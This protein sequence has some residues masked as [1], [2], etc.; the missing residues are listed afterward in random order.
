MLIDLTLRDIGEA[1]NAVD[2]FAP[3]AAAAGAEEALVLALPPEQAC[4]T[5]TVVS[6][7]PVER[8]EFFNTLI[9]LG[10]R[11]GKDIEHPWR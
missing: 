7:A 9:R 11:H 3:A 8:T 1:A 2:M 4:N 6:A 10:S 5:R